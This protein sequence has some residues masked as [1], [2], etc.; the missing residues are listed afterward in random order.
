MRF[1]PS[2]VNVFIYVV[3]GVGGAYEQCSCCETDR[4]PKHV[5]GAHIVQF[6]KPTFK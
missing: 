2:I 6:E 5:G 1:S 3:R 4:A